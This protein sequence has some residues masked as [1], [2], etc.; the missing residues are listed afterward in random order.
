MAFPPIVPRGGIHSAINVIN[1]CR[2][3]VIGYWLLVIVKITEF[4]QQ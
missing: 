1:G 3:L 2:L 4:I